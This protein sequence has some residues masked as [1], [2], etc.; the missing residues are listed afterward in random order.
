MKIILIRHGES[1]HNAG[2]TNGKDTCLT[3]NGILQ[4][5]KLGDYL[6]KQNIK[7]D[8][9]YTSNLIRSKQ[10]GEIISKIIKVPIKKSYE[11]FNE[12]E[13]KELKNRLRRILHRR[14]TN[15]KKLL[16]VIS[17]EK[18]KDKNIIIVA[19]GITN[20]IIIGLLLNIPLKRQLLGFRQNNVGVSE[21]I[22][23]EEHKNWQLEL[24]N[25]TSHLK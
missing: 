8:E 5:K 11:E 10:T 22:W 20:R 7:F 17:K 6:K 3:K 1:E 12:Y 14:L 15:L 16:K 18:N 21:L 9:I 23:E 24:L 4:T 25:D 2:I 13:S 19:H